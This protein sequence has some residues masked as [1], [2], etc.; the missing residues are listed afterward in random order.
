[1]MSRSEYWTPLIP[2]TFVNSVN[3]PTT[4]GSSE[5]DFIMA[6]DGVTCDQWYKL[7][8]N[9]DPN[10]YY[11]TANN[12]LLDNWGASILCTGV[13]GYFP[14]VVKNGA[15]YYM[16]VKGTW[17][18]GGIYLYSSTDKIAWTVMNSGNAVI[19][20]SADVNSW[21]YKIYNAYA[22]IIGTT[23]HI[24][25]DGCKNVSVSPNWFSSGYATADISNPVFT[26]PATATIANGS[27]NAL[28]YSAK[29]NSLFAIY[30]FGRVTN[31]VPVFYARTM[32]A[33][34]TSDL[35]LE[36]SWLKSDLAYPSLGNLEGSEYPSDFSVCFTPGKTNKMM[37]YY[38][39]NQ[40]TGHQAYADYANADDLTDSLFVPSS[41]SVERTTPTQVFINYQL[42]LDNSVPGVSAFTLAGKT[43]TN[44]AISGRRVTL[45]VSVAYTSSDTILLT[46]KKPSANPLKA[47]LNM[48][49]F[50]E[51]SVVNNIA[52]IL[53]ADG[54]EYTSVVIGGLTVLVENLKTTKYNNGDDIQLVTDNAIWTGLITGGRCYYNNDLTTKTP[55]GG[56]Y[57]FFVVADVRG[58]A[59]L[60][61]HVM[62]V[63]EF[64]TIVTTAGGAGLA[65]G[66]LKE[67]GTTHWNAPNTGAVNSLGFTWVGNGYRLPN[68]NYIEFK[69]YSVIGTGVEFDATTAPMKYAAN[70]DDNV[71]SANDLK[72][73][74]F[75]YRCVKD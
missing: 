69:N 30:N 42:P 41:I 25:V 17:A 7:A 32:V 63:A 13:A 11:R 49:S 4:V 28:G 3:N 14:H 29:R 59:P 10:I 36:A 44:V 57:N 67:S 46:Y 48:L 22:V 54:N 26:L 65:G 72:N 74:G 2:L 37:I 31:S 40:A 47:T 35:T 33:S 20:P 21:Y 64:N 12:A 70:V 23:F 5:S 71:A 27:T 19:S 8:N 61:Y 58:V 15:T 39:W 56:L 62:I 43:I 66:V 50:K 73:N 1:M 75:S 16:F 9:G 51:R 45:T 60:G 38:N 34:L 6:D 52:K 68:G 53:D 24:L 55:Y 18:T